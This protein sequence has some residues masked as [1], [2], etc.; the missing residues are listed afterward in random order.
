[1]EISHQERGGKDDRTELKDKHDCY[2]LL[3]VVQEESVA[4]TPAR[5]H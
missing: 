3:D 2:L 5:G 1:M 4:V